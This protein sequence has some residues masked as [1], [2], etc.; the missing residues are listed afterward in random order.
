MDRIKD[1]PSN[2]NSI[3]NGATDPTPE[4]GPKGK[5]W[6]TAW[7]WIKGWWSK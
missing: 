1:I 4:K 2:P 7:S 3:E 6:R 5:G